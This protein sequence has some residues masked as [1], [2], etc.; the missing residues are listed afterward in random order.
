ML[1]FRSSILFHSIA[2]YF[3]NGIR[4]QHRLDFVAVMGDHERAMQSNIIK[5]LLPFIDFFC[6]AKNICRRYW[7]NVQKLLCTEVGNENFVLKIKTFEN[8]NTN[9]LRLNSLTS[10]N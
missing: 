5:F 4:G 7:K 6:V 3:E 10:L 1:S 8:K 9:L 2:R